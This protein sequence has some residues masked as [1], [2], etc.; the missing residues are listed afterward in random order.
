M[1]WGDL[2][3]THDAIAR[4]ASN[5][6]LQHQGLDPQ[7]FVMQVKQSNRIVMVPPE[8][9]LSMYETEDGRNHLSGLINSLIDPSGASAKEVAAQY[10]FLPD[11][12]VQVHEGRQGGQGD[13]P[14]QDCVMIVLHAAEIGSIHVAH[15]VAHNPYLHLKPAPFPGPD[16]IESFGCDMDH[17]AAAVACHD[18]CHDAPR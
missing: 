8:T 10:G 16:L 12:V 6:F 11:V 4:R 7:V 15:P 14:E 3:K 9:V 2:Q 18:T 13:A 1:D 5:I 17:G